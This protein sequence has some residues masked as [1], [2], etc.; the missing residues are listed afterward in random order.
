MDLSV[1]IVTFKSD[2]LIEGLINSILCKT[3]NLAD[4]LGRL[5]DFTNDY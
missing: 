5:K 3:I 1:V 4:F 2:H